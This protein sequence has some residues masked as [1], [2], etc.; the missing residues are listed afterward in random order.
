MQVKRNKLGNPLYN[1]LSEDETKR[2]YE[3]LEEL[4]M[5]F[6]AESVGLAKN[7]KSITT[8]DY[9]IHIYNCPLMSRLQLSINV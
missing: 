1:Y 3:I 6:D 2:I 5:I 4:K 8:E 7:D 9:V